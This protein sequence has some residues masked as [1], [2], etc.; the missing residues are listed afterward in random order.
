MAVVSTSVRKKKN[1]IIFVP[2]HVASR[3]SQKANI[4]S[5]EYFDEARP[6]FKEEDLV[7]PLISTSMGLRVSEQAGSLGWSGGL[8]DALAELVELCDGGNIVVHCEA[9][10][11]RSRNLAERI[12]RDYPQYQFMYNI[13][14]LVDGKRTE[15]VVPH[16]VRRRR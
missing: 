13:P 2:R 12:I 10:Q 5:I 11:H 3:L 4:V 6:E 1:G 7:L 14:Y 8:D 9:G 16:S 15:Y